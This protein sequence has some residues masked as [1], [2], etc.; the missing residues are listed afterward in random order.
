LLCGEKRNERRKSLVVE[1]FRQ[2]TERV[3]LCPSGSFRREEVNKHFPHLKK[4][5]FSEKFCKCFFS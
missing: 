4:F 1:D 3:F 2:A 5:L